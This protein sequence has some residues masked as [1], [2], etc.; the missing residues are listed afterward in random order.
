MLFVDVPKRVRNPNWEELG[1]AP[2]EISIRDQVGRVLD[3]ARI[4]QA[5]QL[6][7]ELLDGADGLRESAARIREGYLYNFGRSAEVAAAELTQLADELRQVG[8]GRA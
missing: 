3:P 5:G 4:D 2:I 1:L 8:A 7:A 6:A